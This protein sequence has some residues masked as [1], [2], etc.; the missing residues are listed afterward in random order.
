MYIYLPLVLLLLLLIF[1]VPVF[2]SMTLSGL[3]GLL[4]VSDLDTLMGVFSTNT[5]SSVANYELLAIPL[6]ILMAN[7]LTASGITSDLFNV[8]QKW[9]GRLPGGLAIS[10]VIAG[11][12][13][14]ALSG[15]STASTAT[16]AGAAVPE[17]NKHGYSTRLS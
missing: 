10:T 3:I 16:L 13:L 6:F 1:G 9:I 15:T 8:A 17:M 14:G 12:G 11:A 2:L 5:F 7:L 4:L